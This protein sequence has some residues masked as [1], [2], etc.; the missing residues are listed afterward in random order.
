MALSYIVVFAPSPTLAYP[1]FHPLKGERKGKLWGILQ[2]ICQ[3]E[4]SK[5][6]LLGWPISLLLL[7]GQN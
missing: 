6:N 5:V 3:S 2:G 4:G 7:A 1:D